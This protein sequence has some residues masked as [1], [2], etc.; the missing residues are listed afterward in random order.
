MITFVAF[1]ISVHKTGTEGT[2]YIA[3]AAQIQILFAVS[4]S[5]MAV[6]ELHFKPEQRLI[7]CRGQKSGK[8]N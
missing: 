6:Q 4:V 7:E 3:L 1:I 2:C 8:L 5:I